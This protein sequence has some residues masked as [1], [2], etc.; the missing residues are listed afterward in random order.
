MS[1]LQTLLEQ[2]ESTFGIRICVHDVSGITFT[3]RSLE[4]PYLWKTHGGTY[5]TQ[6][7]N[8]ISEQSCMH[9]KEIAL[10]VLQR[11]GGKPYCG[12]CRM[13][14]CDYIE[15][16]KLD[17][18]LIA[19]IFASG[20]IYEK[21]DDARNRLEKELTRHRAD[22]GLLEDYACFAEH[23]LTTEA[24]L[25]FFAVL[26]RDQILHAA[27]GSSHRVVPAQDK[28]PVE[29][30]R[31]WRSGM[32]AILVNYLEENYRKHITLK[33]LS[34][35]FLISE[36]HIDRLVRKEVHMGAISYLKHLRLESASK[37]LVQTE[38][39]IYEIGEEVG[40]NEPNY[41]CRIFKASYGMTPLEYRDRY[42]SMHKESKNVQNVL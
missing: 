24:R 5:C 8:A 14:V 35:R 7:K 41:F 39:H 20:V 28:Y 30:V 9:Q 29:S 19:V 37:A 4:L 12:I 38:K 42:S 2:I 17:G 25:R 6:A 21:L 11:N 23:A 1:E 18:R 33:M 13:G 16:V 26:V 10:Y 3:V 40:Y 27:Q 22:P 32:S 36:G 34:Q 31:T 15:P